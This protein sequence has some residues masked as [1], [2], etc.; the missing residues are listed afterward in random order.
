[1]VCGC[2]GAYRPCHQSYLVTDFLDIP[3]G[4]A[5]RSRS[6]VGIPKVFYLLGMI[7]APRRCL[8]PIIPDVASWS[9]V[10][11]PGVWTTVYGYRALRN[12]SSANHVQTVILSEAQGALRRQHV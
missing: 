2:K 10:A 8:G 3:S 11:S 4:T 12:H 7:T 9:K 1:M 6:N 5:I